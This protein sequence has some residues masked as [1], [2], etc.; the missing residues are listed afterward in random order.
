MELS[1]AGRLRAQE[2]PVTPE[3]PVPA[4]CTYFTNF[5]QYSARGPAMLQRFASAPAAA[6]RADHIGVRTQAVAKGLAAVSD[7]PPVASVGEL[8]WID[9]YIFS[10][11]EARGMAPANLTNDAEFLRRVTLD[12]TGRIPSAEQVS[13]FQSDFYPRKRQRMIDLLL[14]TPEWEDR[15]TMWLGD[16][17]KNNVRSTQN[18]RYAEGRDAF[19]RFIRSSLAENKPYNRF[20]AEV[21]TASG[22]SFENGAVNFNLGGRMSMGPVQD[23]YDKQWVQVAGTFLGLKNF[24]CVLC[25]DGAGHLDAVNLWASQVTRA[26]AWGLAAFFSRLR[27]TRYPRENIAS[28]IAQDAAAGGYTLNTDSGNRPTRAPAEGQPRNVTPQYLFSGRRAGLSENYRQVLAEEVTS[29]F[30][31]ARATVNYIWAHFFGI[32]IVDPPDAFDLAR[33]DPNNPPPE[34][35]TIQPSHPQLLDELARFFIANN[36]DLKALMREITNSNAYQLS[37]RYEGPWNPVDAP[38]QAR[39]LV[40][41]LDAEELHDALAQASGIPGNMRLREY[42]EPI[43]WAM[44]LPDTQTPGGAVGAFLDTFLRGDRDENPRRRDLSVAQALDLMN[45]PFVI[46][47][48]RASNPNGMLARLLASEVDNETFVR[49]LY[50]SVLSRYPT[51][52]EV[53]TSVNLLAS[54]P[55]RQRAEDLL[56]SLYNKVDFVFNY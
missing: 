8:T 46:A 12:L 43:Q 34:P 55:R 42:P 15:W 38:W 50:M 41:R 6:L 36:Y 54:G 10:A 39:H 2:E 9:S 33:L 25:H 20:V 19:N 56:W 52:D 22:D 28:F 29:D 48:S 16:L 24:D 18:V 40:R 7:G 51:S 21:I 3:E 44:Q 14:A 4:E 1:P 49:T 17:L 37:S 5:E 11:L 26:Q 35:W 30:Q 13:T 53:V 45:D 47:R 27:F 31:F 23:T 32:G